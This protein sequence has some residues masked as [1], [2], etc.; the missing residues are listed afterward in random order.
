MTQAGSS[1]RFGFVNGY[2]KKPRRRLFEVLR[3]QGMQLNQ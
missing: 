2:D 3:D 1:R